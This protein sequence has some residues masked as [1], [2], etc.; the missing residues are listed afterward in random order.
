MAAEQASLTRGH[1]REPAGRG[2]MLSPFPEGS[3]LERYNSKGKVHAEDN[4][5]R[6]SLGLEKKG[7]LNETEQLLA[8]LSFQKSL[9]T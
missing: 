3:I 2:K 4:S 9:W 5:Q 7:H 8:S 1:P 6:D